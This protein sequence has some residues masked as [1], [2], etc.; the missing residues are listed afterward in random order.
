MEAKY[1]NERKGVYTVYPV[2]VPLIQVRASYP[3]RCATNPDHTQKKVNTKMN[4]KWTRES[5]F[6]KEKLCYA[7]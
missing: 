6:V 2:C 7:S 5:F 4:Q 3:Q 1:L